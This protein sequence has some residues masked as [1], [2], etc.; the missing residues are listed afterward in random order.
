MRSLM[1]SCSCMLFLFVG[2]SAAYAQ[3]PEQPVPVSPPALRLVLPP[4]LHAV[5]GVECNIYFD[6]VVLTP[7]VGDY[8]FD[9]DC[10]KGVQQAER[11]TW[12]PSE[13]DLGNHALAMK[14]YDSNYQV[15]A[16]GTT[17]LRVVS[18]KAAADRK[19]SYLIIGDSLTAASVY[20]AELNRLFSQ[21][22]NLQVT[23]IGT[24]D[25][26]EG[27]RHEGYGGWTAA[28]FASR[29]TAVVDLDN[30]W[31]QRSPFLFLAD[32]KPKLDFARYCQE[33]NGGAAPDYITIALGCND[34]FGATEETIEESIGSFLT[35]M[36]ILIAEFRR[37]GPNTK[38]GIVMLVPPSASQ[39]AFGANYRCGQTR[40][41]YRRNQHRVVER[42][43]ETYGNRVAEN[44]F[45]IPAHVNLDCVHN[46]PTAAGPAN[47]RAETELTR[48]SN[49][50][51][52]AATGY[53][54]MADS[55]YCWIIGSLTE[56]Q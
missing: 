39:D 1:Y 49:G 48:A 34:N 31:R 51:H 28:S 43:I 6:N 14:V 5:P 33:N 53:R 45:L 23:L 46:Y 42:L 13:E 47:S 32:D 36:D 20:P 40:Y 37:V 7:N 52:P 19:L 35:N 41:Q 29:W 21:E 9:V 38:I 12:I 27:V 8:L 54:Q 4:V 15:I 55:I 3:T 25:R 10:A 26:G 2:F 17:Q 30:S 44:V 22:G 56:G 50:V 16:E 11:Y 24:T 18:P